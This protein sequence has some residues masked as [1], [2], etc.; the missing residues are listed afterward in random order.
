MFEVHFKV[1]VTKNKHFRL[2]THIVN[3]FKAINQQSNNNNN[4]GSL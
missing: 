3:I 4:N 1:N 2:V